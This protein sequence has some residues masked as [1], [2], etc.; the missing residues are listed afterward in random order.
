[1]I[2]SVLISL[3]VLLATQAVACEIPIGWKPMKAE[4]DSEFSVIA[5]LPAQPIKTGTQFNIDV[6]IC[7]GAGEAARVEID[8]N[9]PAHKHGMNYL[10]E[11]SALDAMNYR[12]SGLFFHMPGLWQLTVEL[13]GE[14]TQRFF[15][16]VVAK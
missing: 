4:D 16:D 8:A 11:V 5:Q 13:K 1:M 12:A 15:V 9:M 7:G 2:R 10:P 14:K 3:L 6:M